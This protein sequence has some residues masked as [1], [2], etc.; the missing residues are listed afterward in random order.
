MDRE[1]TPPQP[2]RA[3]TGVCVP[4]KAT[5]SGTDENWFHNLGTIGRSSFSV[6]EHIKLNVVHQ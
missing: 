3:P 4:H 2:E 6:V 1:E 5:M